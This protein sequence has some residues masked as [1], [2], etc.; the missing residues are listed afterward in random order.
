L[1]EQA[2]EFG[3]EAVAPADEFETGLLLRLDEVHAVCLVKQRFSK[4]TDSVDVL[5]V[6]LVLRSWSIPQD[7]HL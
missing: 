1:G 6:C 2:L 3:V 7:L 5:D 4:E